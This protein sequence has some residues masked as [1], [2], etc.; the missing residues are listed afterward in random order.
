L[1]DFARRYTAAWRS[2]DPLLVAAHYSLEGSLAINGGSPAVG[3]AAIADAARSFMTAFPDMRV[4]MDNLEIREDR[5]L[6][7][8]TLKGTNTGA[9]GTGRRI[10]IS[11]CEQWEIGPD[12]LIAASQGQFDS[13]DYQR[14]LGL[15]GDDAR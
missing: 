9:G 7:R 8:W 15:G 14:Q 11:G 2:Q 12:G 1:L 6:Y 5:A 4:T 3:R 10:R 13:E